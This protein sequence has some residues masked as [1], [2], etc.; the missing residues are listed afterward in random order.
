[1]KKLFLLA[2]TLILGVSAI[3]Q[4][5]IQLRSADRA[6]CVKSDMTGLKASFSFSTIEAQ[7]YESERGTF[8]WLSLPNTVIGGN[9][10][11]P[12]IPVINQLIAVPFGANPSIEITSYS[13]TDYRLS[14]YDMKTLVPRQLPVRKSQRPEDVPF[15]MNEAAYQVR[16]LRSEPQ[17]IVSVEGTMRG[18][19]LGKMT[20][21]P[22]S[23]DPVNNTI[24]VFNDIEVTVH[25]DGADRQATEQMLIDTY[26]PYFDI[27]YKSLFNGRTITDAYS[28]HPDLYSTPVKMLVVTTSTYANSDAFNTWLTWKKQKGIEVDVQTVTSSTTAANVRSL[29]QAQYNA[30]HPTFLVI[31]GDESAVKYYTTYSESGNSYNPYISD[32][33]YASI[34]SD[35][36][37]DM[38]MSRMAVSSTTELQNLVNK[39][40]TYEKYTMSDPSYLNNVLLIAGNDT[41]TGNWDEAVGRPTIQYAVNNYYNAAHGF[42]NVYK[43]NTSSTYTGC[44]NYLS[45]GVGFLNYT[46]HGAINALS[47]PSFTVSN[48]SSLTNNDKY[49]WIVANCC[50]SANWGNTSTSPC[51]G[52]AMI[53]A[54]NKGAFGYIGSVPETLWYEDYYFGVGAFSYVAQ[55]VQTTSST[56]TGMYD[57]LFDDTGFNTLNSVPYIGNVAVTYAHAK[58]YQSS[59]NDEYYWRAYQCL[60]DGSVMPYLVRPAANNVSHNNTIPAGSST[61]RVNADARSY[62]S[63]TVDNEIIGVAAVPANATYVDVPFTTTPQVGQTAMIVVTRNQRQPYINNNVQIVGGEQYNITATASPTA[64]GTV[65]GAGQ[66]YENTDCTLTA[67]PNHG[68]AFDNW[69][70]GNTVVSTEPTYTFT[71]TGNA[72][73]TANFHALTEH[74]ITYNPNQTN[75]TISVSPTD[76]YVGDIVT[77]TATPAAGYCLDQWHVTTGRAEVPVVNNQFTMPDSDVTIT[78]TFKSGYTVTVATV[79][80]GTITA[81]PTSAMPG[82]IITLTATPNIGCEFMT[83]NAYKTGDPNTAVTVFNNTIR[84]PS[85]DVTVSAVFATSTIADPI[86]I[87]SGTSTNQYLPTYTYYNYSL[88]QQIYTAAELGEAGSITAIA[89]QVGNSKASTRNLSIYM[90]PTDL[91]A[92]TSTT[93]W[94]T[95]G[96]VYLVYSGSVSFNASGWTTIQLDTPFKY[97]GVKNV[98]ICVVDNSGSY[99]TNGNYP[100]FMVYSTGA[101]RA[102]RVYNDDNAYSVGTS[103]QISTYTGTYVTSNNQIQITKKLVN[104]ETITVAPTTIEGLSYVQGEGPSETKVVDVTGVDLSNNIT[105]TAPNGFEISTAANGTYGTSLTIPRATSKGGRATQTWGFEGSMEN[106]TNVDADGDTWGWVLGSA[107]GGVYLAAGNN[108][109]E[110]HSGSD[111]MVSGSYSNVNGVLTPD[112][113]LISPQVELGGTFSMWA[114]GQDASWFAEHFGIYVST[115]NNSISSFTALNEF[116]ATADWKQY[117]V[118]LS[119]FAGQTGYIAIRHFDCTNMFMLDVDDFEL[120]TEATFTPDLPVVI[121]PAT[122]YVRLQDGLDPDTY[123][124]NM[125]FVA[126][127]VNAT[128]A[129]NGEVLPGSGEQYTITVEASPTNGGTVTGG[130]TY[131]EG[132]HHDLT[133]TPAAHYTFSGWQL[134][135]NIVST[136]NPYNITVTGDATYTAVF[137]PMTQHNVA[138]TQVTGCTITA[139]PTSA[140]AGD[141]ITLTASAQSGYFFVEWNV[142][143]ANNQTVTV[144]NNQFT[145]P[146]SNVTVTAVVTQGFTVHLEQTANGT[147]SADQTTGLQPG[148]H[149]TLTATPDNGC[150]FLA[151]YVYKTGSPRDVISVVNDEWFFMPSNDVTVQAIFVTEEEHEQTIG[152]GTSTNSYLPTYVYRRTV[153]HSL[154]QQIYTA[155]EIGY[156]GRITAIAFK[157]NGS[158]TRNLDIYMAHTDKTSFSSNTD[159]EVMGSVAKVYS[160]SVS[161]TNNWTTITLDTPFEYDGT[162]NLNICVVD[163]TSGQVSN[164]RAFSAYSTG[165]NRAM[166]VYSTGNSA[167]DYSTVIGYSNQLESTTGT[168]STS[169]N[170]IKF[171]IKVPGSAESLTVSPGEIDDFS[172]V[173]GQGPSA[174]NKLGIVGVDLSNDITLTAPAN[175]EISLTENGTYSNSLTIARETGSK[176]N[177]DV[178]TWDFEDGLQGWTVADAD[179]DGYNWAHST[180]FE[181]HD[182]ST[183]I[184]FSQ[185]YDNNAGVLTPDNWLISPQVTLGGSFSMWAH[186]QQAAYPAEHFAILVS[187][188]NTNV[189]SF[190][191][192]GEWTLSSG[193]WKHFSVDLSAFAGQTGYIAVRHYNCT[194]QFYINVDDFVLDTDAAITIDLPVTITPATVYVR[195]KENLSAGNYN[196]TLTASAGTGDNLNGSVSLAG[197]VIVDLSTFTRDIVGYSSSSDGWYLIASPIGQVAP[198]NVGNMLADPAKNYDLFSFDQTQQNEWQNFKQGHFSNLEPGYGYLY[199]NK[200]NVTLTFTGSA[201]TTTDGTYDVDLVYS[202]SNGDSFMHGWNLVGNP[203]AETASVSRPFYTLDNQFEYVAVQEGTVEAMEGIF[204]HV[205]AAE[206]EQNNHQTVTFTKGAASSKGSSLTLNVNKGGKFVDRAIISFSQGGTLPKFQFNRNH[207]KVYIPQ[208]GQ[209]YAIVR[210]E[211]MGEMPVNFKAENN[212]TYSLSFS[213]QNAE[214]AYLHLIDNMTG[215]D[216]DLLQTQSYS[217]E[218]RTTDYESRFKLV[219]ATGDNSKDDNFAFF[220]NGSFIINNEGE[221]T[222]QVIDVTGRILKSASINGCTNVN[223][224]AAS[225]IYMLRL[226]NGDNVKVQKVVVK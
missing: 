114:K 74:H 163:V 104:A 11:D 61:F 49:F 160:G 136:A 208:D 98:N 144:T 82:D 125:T 87:G 133:A 155:A 205:T 130:G 169:N 199:A 110:G 21:E 213:S 170:Q 46:A 72:T 224:N 190:T 127:T 145:M 20:I 131:Y 93:G 168:R 141:V 117:S 128:V 76:A 129:L 5:K 43:Y 137:T 109:S 203:F 198:S 181:G 2:M 112:N 15:I 134:N 13:T 176:G 200:E 217:F 147:I 47:D 106:W 222:L 132:T 48:V 201:F 24:R 36:Y 206:Y 44:Y 159:W 86:T 166:Y 219:F 126:G 182:G 54:A 83:W 186:P 7:D 179:G 120:N 157:A 63:I 80:N 12:Q 39:I 124:G 204:V 69:K 59:V 140:Y 66:H 50:L 154:T 55:T 183:G 30:N 197:Q 135:G 172:Y 150:V 41:S 184:I 19:Q 17:A 156:N 4:Q 223:V 175:F 25:F 165:A 10:G 192:L 16:G 161:F 65:E 84:M 164:T 123:S 162:S 149:V 23:Y 146:D 38:Y 116:T 158:V 89:F 195:M 122:V 153:C 187:T 52:E 214:F 148:D 143:D 218:A 31:V 73:Y 3:A 207:T 152:S 212:G 6:E 209:D 216:V 138:I 113:W 121:T 99:D 56:S 91:T 35:V 37:H 58:G 71:V 77:L 193:D 8:S 211:E 103:D 70:Q 105:V 1:M 139:N 95:M 28:D 196:G 111:M 78:A 118:D 174:T 32:N 14:D 100:Y 210:S 53:R 26:S 90:R 40:L 79:A 62:V 22:V 221:A 188:T 96:D 167:T 173:E 18:V 33:Q 57:A 60:G 191:M 194:D 177:R 220:S 185:S 64:G 42:T 107:V 180:S 171:T 115:T 102:M 92:F 225:G 29:I 45:S 189:S 119:F 81:N 215:A 108:M 75:G 178:Q 27:V 51:L 202:T 88:T 67:T 85:Y 142:V 97:D 34:D 94:E 9:E 101:N 151:W 68:Y 226:V